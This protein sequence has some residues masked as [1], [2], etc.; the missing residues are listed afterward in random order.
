MR[1][2]VFEAPAREERMVLD[3]RR[4]DRAIG[5]AVLARFFSFKDKDLLPLKAR[6]LVRER[7]E[8]V[9]RMRNIGVAVAGV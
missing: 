6:R 2:G 1:I 7:A 4:N 8:L 3:Q 5:V 9:D